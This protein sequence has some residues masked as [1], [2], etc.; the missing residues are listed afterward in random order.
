MV[1]FFNTAISLLV[2]LVLFLPAVILHEIAHG[3][4]AWLLGDDTAKRAGRLKPHTHFDL[5]GSFLLPLF[6]F[7][8]KSPVFF[9]YAKPVPIDIRKLKHG[10]LDFALVALAGPL[11]NFLLAFL[12]IYLIHL[13][14]LP[15]HWFLQSFAQLNLFLAFF[16]MIPIPPLDGS[17][18]VAC[19][20]PPGLLSIYDRLER[21][22]IIVI[23]GLQIIS[24]YLF[25]I[26]GLSGS[27]LTYFV[28]IPANFVLNHMAN[29]W[30]VYLAP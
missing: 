4:V 6:L 16:N 10:R 19:L 26:I 7:I 27:L 15:K 29:F 12:S 23:I 18:L 21:V 25:P 22:G 2:F 11:C 5:Y 1:D 3:V 17:R 24:V 13:F 14:D 28:Q 8:C 30:N 20:L 9:A